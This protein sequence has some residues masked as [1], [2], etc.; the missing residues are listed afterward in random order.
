MNS[1]YGIQKLQGVVNGMTIKGKTD[2]P[3]P[4]CQVCTH[5]TRKR[6]PDV[7]A[8]AASEFVHTNVAG[9]TDPG[10]RDGYRFPLSFIIES[11]LPKEL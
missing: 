7:R 6:D 11:K 1:C 2:K 3:V 10:A 8:K 5:G 9:P 4:H